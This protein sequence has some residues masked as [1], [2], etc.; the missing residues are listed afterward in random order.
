MGRE[1]ERDS[2]MQL[3]LPRVS[4]SSESAVL[5]EMFAWSQGLMIWLG[6]R[7]EIE[8]VR[9]PTL[10]QQ[11]QK[12]IQWHMRAKLFVA[13]IARSSRSSSRSRCASHPIGI[14]ESWPTSAETFP[15]LVLRYP[16]VCV[17]NNTSTKKLLIS[18][19]CCGIVSESLKELFSKPWS[20]WTF[21]RSR[22]WVWTAK[23]GHQTRFAFVLPWLSHLAIG[24]VYSSCPFLFVMFVDTWP[25]HQIFGCDCLAQRLAMT[26]GR[27]SVGSWQPNRVQVA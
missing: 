26:C 1:R 7:R 18:G 13:C 10:F 14:P 9:Q 3:L 16:R 24:L 22:W 11:T 17:R 8:F 20:Q 12:Q 25:C 19:Y 5:V 4:G 2:A 21:W 27:W 6:E 15:F 23:A